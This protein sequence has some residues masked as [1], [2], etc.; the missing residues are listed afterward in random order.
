MRVSKLGVRASW[1]HGRTRGMCRILFGGMKGVWIIGIRT[2]RGPSMHVVDLGRVGYCK[3]CSVI[4]SAGMIRMGAQLGGVWLVIGVRIWGEGSWLIFLLGNQCT[5][6]IVLRIRFAVWACRHGI[7]R[8]LFVMMGMLV[9]WGRWVG[10]WYH[11]H[12]I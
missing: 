4:I 3:I 11:C 2:G 5:W 8:V 1:R 12:P 9:M 7:R 10:S 6:G